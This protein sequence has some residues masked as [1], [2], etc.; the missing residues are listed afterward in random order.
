MKCKPVLIGIFS[1]LFLG[2]T[3]K[4]HDSAGIDTK[5]WQKSWA[6]VQPGI[7][8]QKTEVSNEGFRIF[9]NDLKAGGRL[10]EWKA[11]YPDSTGWLNGTLNPLADYYFN[12]A[13]YND[14]PVVNI[15]Y[16]AARAYCDWLTQTYARNGKKPFGEVIFRLPTREEWMMAA[17]SSKNDGRQYPWNG[18]YLHNSRGER[19]CNFKPDSGYNAGASDA[20][21]PKRGKAF[22]APQGTGLITSPVQSFFPNDLGLYNVCGNAAEMLDEKGLAAGGSFEDTGYF[23]RISSTSRYNGSSRSVGFRVVMQSVAA[24]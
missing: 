6:V 10:Q 18:M 23:V 17:S 1:W 2:F 19:L 15:T 14:Y 12:H 4:K 3:T 11:C 13:A 8:I 9:L 22:V 7:R 24:R 21:S 16:E 20:G 5:T